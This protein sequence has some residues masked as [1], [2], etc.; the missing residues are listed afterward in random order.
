MSKQRVN[1]SAYLAVLRLGAS[2]RYVTYRAAVLFET[3]LL[4]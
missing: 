2:P 4:S 1:G 3:M